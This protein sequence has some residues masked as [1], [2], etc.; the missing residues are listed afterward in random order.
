M[1]ASSG[2]VE[3]HLTHKFKEP[4]GAAPKQPRHCSL[5]SLCL[6]KW[7]WRMAKKNTKTKKKEK[8][9]KP[10]TIGTAASHS[11][12]YLH[13]FKIDTFIAF[14]SLG[15]T[16]ICDVRNSPFSSCGS[17]VLC[18]I[19]VVV[20]KLIFLS[21]LFPVLPINTFSRRKRQCSATVATCQKKEVVDAC[22]SVPLR[23][24]L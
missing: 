7:V 23:C 10:H 8:K 4:F 17:V 18:F 1:H 5:F 2:S 11:N 24:C 22:V 14:F 3:M 15:K 13:N 9:N 19:A 6:T 12:W 20:F 16:T 21:R